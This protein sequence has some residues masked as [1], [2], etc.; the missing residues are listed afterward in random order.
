MHSQSAPA[1]VVCICARSQSAPAVVCVCVCLCVC[2][3]YA[4]AVVCVCVVFCCVVSIVLRVVG[5]FFRYVLLPSLQLKAFL[6]CQAGSVRL[7]TPGDFTVLS[8]VSWVKPRG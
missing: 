2:S 6:H 7:G 3:P 5:C 1:N 4:T 8:Q